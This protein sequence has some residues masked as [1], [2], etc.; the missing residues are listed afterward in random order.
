MLGVTPILP[1]T[2]ENAR[3][4]VLVGARPAPFVLVHSRGVR[5][6]VAPPAVHRGSLPPTFRSPVR[7]QPSV[8]GMA[9]SLIEPGGRGLVAAIDH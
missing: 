1:L 9:A 3:Q 5:H 4:S 8:W 2:S 6:G 7:W